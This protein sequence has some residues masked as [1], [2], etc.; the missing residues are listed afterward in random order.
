MRSGASVRKAWPR[1]ATK[2][3]ENRSAVIDIR[4][5]NC[6][7]RA[8][9]QL[10]KLLNRTDQPKKGLIHTL[11]L[12][13]ALIS[14]LWAKSESDTRP[15]ILLM[16]PDQ[17]RYDWGGLANNPYYSR[18]NLP[19][20]TPNFDKLALNG[21]RFTRAVVAAPVCA[22]SRACLAAGSAD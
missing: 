19:L 20:K 1:Q 2:K 18:A 4:A 6:D 10:V 8:E 7:S 17:L 13:P 22:P 3:K 21:V 12:L 9:K 14:L 16:F 15:N 11:M 5:V